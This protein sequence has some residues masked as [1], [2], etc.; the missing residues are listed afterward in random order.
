[1]EEGP[2]LRSRSLKELSRYARPVEKRPGNLKME[3]FGTYQEIGSQFEEPRQYISKYYISV[4][5]YI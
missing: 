3:Y 2:D 5:Q 1:M 4:I